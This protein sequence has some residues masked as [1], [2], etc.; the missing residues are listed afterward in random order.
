MTKRN[1][2]SL[3]RPKRERGLNLHDT[4]PIVYQTLFEHEPLLAGVKVIGE[5]FCGKGNGVMAMRARGIKVYASDILDRGC[6]DS[7]VLDFRQMTQRPPDC[8]TLVSNPAYD[9]AAGGALDFIEH[10][11][12][13][14]FRVIALLLKL[15]F[16]GTA[17]RY[18]R[19]H[20]LGHLRRVH[21]IIERIQGMH[22]A[23]HLAAGG[24]LAGQSQNHGWFV[25]DRSYYGKPDLN[26]VS[27]NDPTARMPWA[28]GATEEVFRYVPHVDVPKFQAKGWQATPA[29]DGTH[30]GEY[31]VLMRAPTAEAAE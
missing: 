4:P 18:E 5:F 24:K 31:S 28:S 20:P 30:H 17:E 7:T 6:P 23:G 11:F 15:Q 21:I 13:L 19:L 1:R 8:D 29:L 9:G 22:D 12:A 14:G 26:F 3:G 27:I 25:F 16:L 10:A 2:P